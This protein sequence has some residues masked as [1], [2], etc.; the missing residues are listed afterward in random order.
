MPL[1]CSSKILRFLIILFFKGFG[2]PPLCLFLVYFHG[3]ELY[4]LFSWLLHNFYC[5]FY[6]NLVLLFLT[7]TV[8]CDILIFNNV[9]L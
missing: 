6:T 7:V 9:Y 1:D 8:R 4:H 3:Y 5:N 2:V